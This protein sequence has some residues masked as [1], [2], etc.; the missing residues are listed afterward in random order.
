MN[1]ISFDEPGR[2]EPLEF[3]VAASDEDG[4]QM[5][6]CR[7]PKIMNIPADNRSAC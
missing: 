3:I 1:W 2:F 5:R 7:N 6:C 4:G